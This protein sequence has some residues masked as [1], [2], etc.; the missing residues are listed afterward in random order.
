[1]EPPFFFLHWKKYPPF[2]HVVSFFRYSKQIHNIC[3]CESNFGKITEFAYLSLQK[4]K[5][6][7]VYIFVVKYIFSMCKNISIVAAVVI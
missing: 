1:M 7:I 4:S 5:Y 3:L 2:N 6:K